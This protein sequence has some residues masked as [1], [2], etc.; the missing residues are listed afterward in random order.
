MQKSALLQ[1][2]YNL[3]ASIVKESYVRDGEFQ[4][5]PLAERQYARTYFASGQDGSADREALKRTIVT[6]G[7]AFLEQQFDRHVDKTI[8]AHPTEAQLGG[9][10]G[11]ANKIRGYVDVKFGLG[12]HKLNLESVGGTYLW[13]QVYYLLRAGYP[14]EALKTLQ[15]SLNSLSHHDRLLEGWFK[16]WLDSQDRR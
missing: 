11:I 10:P 3:L 5:V 16:S 8:A 13:A 14:D 15:S 7:R 12:K 2:T 9:I 1:P 4:S 6:G